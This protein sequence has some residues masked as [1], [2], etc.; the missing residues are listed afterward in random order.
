MMIN[1]SIHGK[2]DINITTSNL[3]VVSYNI[4]QSMYAIA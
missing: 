1:V 3:P 4:L 2:H